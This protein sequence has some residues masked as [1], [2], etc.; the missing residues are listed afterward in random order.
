MAKPLVKLHGDKKIHLSAGA[1][2]KKDGKLL[3]IDR[4][5]KPYGLAGPAGHVDQGESPLQAVKREVQEETGLEVTTAKLILEEFVPWNECSRGV[6]GHHFY[7]Y[8][9]EVRGNINRSERE[10][11]SIGWY[12]VKDVEAKLEPVWQ[13]IFKK[14]GML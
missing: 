8:N 4:A 3:L 9:C 10:T 12:D 13:Y 6:K 2:I 1:L 11:K 5:V 14:L 7:I